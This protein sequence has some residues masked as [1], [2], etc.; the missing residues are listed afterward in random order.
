MSGGSWEYVMGNIVSSDGTTMMSG[1]SSSS[2]SGYT[3]IIYDSG[4]YTSYTGSY[5]Y[6]ENKYLDKYSFGTSNTQR[7]RSKLGDAVKEVYNTES[8]LWHGDHSSLN[9]SS[10]PWFNR[11]GYYSNN[12]LAGIFYS[13]GIYGSAHSDRSFR[14][15]ITP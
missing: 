6:P 2:N 8:Y 3:G 1:Y 13:N 9:I 14:L 12:S 4:N 7:I 5:S 11:G 15:V 10:Y